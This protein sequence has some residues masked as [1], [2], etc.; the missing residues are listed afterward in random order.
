VDIVVHGTARQVTDNDE[1]QAVANAYAAKY[2]WNPEVKDATLIAVG[3]PSA[4]DP[5]FFVY[6][7]EPNEAFALPTDGEHTPTRFRPT[8]C[9]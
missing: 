1:C 6:R 3:A 2:G 8:R 9:P 7:V 4:G 5:P